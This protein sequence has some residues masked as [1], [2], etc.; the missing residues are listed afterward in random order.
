MLGVCG[1]GYS[2]R[3]ETQMLKKKKG[4]RGAPKSL[5]HHHLRDASKETCHCHGS[6]APRVWHTQQVDR[7]GI[8]GMPWAKHS[9]G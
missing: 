6:E 7:Y 9:G 3:V 5:L 2:V 4:N 1:I 8:T